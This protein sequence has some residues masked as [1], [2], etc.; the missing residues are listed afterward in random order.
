MQK[1]FIKRPISSL[2]PVKQTTPGVGCGD[3]YGADDG[4]EVTSNCEFNECNLH[5]KTFITRWVL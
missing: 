3:G 4:L 2:P 5:E 1:L